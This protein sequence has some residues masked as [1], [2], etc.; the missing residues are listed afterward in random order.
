MEEVFYTK[1]HYWVTVENDIA[2][3]GLGNYVLENFND[4][5]YIEIEQNG[6]PCNKTD[7]IGTILADGEEFDLCAP[8]TGEIMEVNEVLEEEPL[9][10]K[11][12]STEISWLYKISVINKAELED[13]LSEEEYDE[14]LNNE[15]NY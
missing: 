12:A 9:N 10:I 11:D 4:I 6:T 3:V 14:Y 7:I 5:S 8:F 13:L 2:T 1:E 15:I